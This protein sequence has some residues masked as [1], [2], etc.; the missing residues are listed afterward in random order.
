[1]F[2][3]QNLFLSNSVATIWKRFVHNGAEAIF[4]L[5]LDFYYHWPIHQIGTF[6]EF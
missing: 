3:R 1:M 2:H 5:Q 4:K 6:Y